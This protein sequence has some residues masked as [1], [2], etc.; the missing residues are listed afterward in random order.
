[1]TRND[2]A[3]ACRARYPDRVI[4]IAGDN[5]HQREAAGKPNVGRERAEQAVAAIGGLTLLPTVA[6][7]DR[8]SDWNDLARSDG[9]DTA[10]QQLMAAVAV[11]ERER[12]VQGLA[13]DRDRENDRSPP[14]SYA[15]ERERTIEAETYVASVFGFVALLV[16]AAGAV[17]G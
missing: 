10:R 3:Q 8:G 5:D 17:L 2:F 6:G 15:L 16:L 12:V 7:Q 9:R 14:R 1:M 11:A 13:A 4:Y